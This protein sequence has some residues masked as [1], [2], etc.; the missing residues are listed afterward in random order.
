MSEQEDLFDV[1]VIDPSEV[2]LILVSNNFDSD[3]ALSLFEDYVDDVDTILDPDN[4]QE[5]FSQ[6]FGYMLAIAPEEMVEEGFSLTR[7]IFTGDKSVIITVDLSEE[8]QNYLD[9]SYE[10][11]DD[12]YTLLFG[13]ES[14]EAESQQDD[15]AT[16]DEED[17][18]V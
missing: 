3:F 5:I 10:T 18:S 15:S 6:T 8:L 17:W 7:C 14:Q 16:D 12:V 11:S 13:E 9:D 1:S 2:N 4:Q